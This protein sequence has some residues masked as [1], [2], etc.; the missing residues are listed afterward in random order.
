M[1]ARENLAADN[2]YDKIF[3]ALVLV[4]AMVHF[5]TVDVA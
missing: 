5:H 1:T 2:G 3:F 4:I